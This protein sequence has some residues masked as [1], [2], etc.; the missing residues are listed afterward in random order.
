M[1]RVLKY[2]DK[3]PIS[4]EFNIYIPV[5]IEFGS[6]DISIEPTVYWR[7]G[8]SKKSVMEI[9][10]GRYRGDIRSVALNFCDKVNVLEDIN[11][12]NKKIMEGLP[13]VQFDKIWSE[14]YIDEKSNLKIYLY[15][16]QVYILFSEKEIMSIIQND[17][18]GF[19]LDINNDIC[20]ILAK[21]LNEND[22]AAFLQ[23]EN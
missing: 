17:R 2:K 20:C 16:D 12:S 15:K 22:K 21:G 3:K 4:M 9:G 1:L 6:W 10:I 19:G 5:Y 8:D 18:V 23:Y 11:I 13:I 14:T 7:I